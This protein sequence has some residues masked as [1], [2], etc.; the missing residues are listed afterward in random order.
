MSNVHS[1]YTTKKGT[2]L[3]LM[4]M[5][6]K[7]YMQVAQRLIW[8]TEDVESY[9][10]DV[11]FPFIDENETVAFASIKLFDSAGKVVKS[12]TATKR[13]S[14]AHFIDHTEKAETGAIG[15]ALAM[16]GFGTQFA[17]ADLE[18]GEKDGSPRVVDS[19]VLTK[20]STPSSS[21]PAKSASSGFGVTEKK[22]VPSSMKFGQPKK[23][24][25]ENL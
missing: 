21:S 18:E 2:Q 14:K 7:P 15:R 10:I 11:S 5:K 23:N 25:G 4:S 12:V 8:F 24:L 17:V 1:V 16:L 3:P 22:E 6:G 13:E 9:S 20:P 19:P